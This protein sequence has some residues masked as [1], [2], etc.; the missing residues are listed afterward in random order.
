MSIFSC[1]NVQEVIYCIKFSFHNFKNVLEKLNQEVIYMYQ[2]FISQ[3]IQLYKKRLKLAKIALNPEM[4][5]TYFQIFCLNFTTEI[6]IIVKNVIKITKIL[7]ITYKLYQIQNH[8]VIIGNSTIFEKFYFFIFL[9]HLFLMFSYYLS[10]FYTCPM[11]A[12]YSSEVSFG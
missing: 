12:K 3:F 4:N 1:K 8:Y 2:I 10:G 11:R 5:S 7:N 9:F 6:S